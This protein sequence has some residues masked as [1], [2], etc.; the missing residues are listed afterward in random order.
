MKK[1]FIILLIILTK[2]LYSNIEYNQINNLFSGNRE[3]YIKKTIQFY[4]D[5]FENWNYFFSKPQQII[6]QNISGRNIDTVKVL[7]L[8]V[9]FHEDTSS[10]TTGNG[11]FTFSSNGEPEYNNDGT[12]NLNYDPPH[13]LVYFEH[14]MEALRNYYIDDTKGHLEIEYNIFPLGDTLS[15]ISLPH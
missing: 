3:K 6:R 15:K 10:L 9:D 8:R 14:Q 11:K 4:E 12:H 2:L 1:N 13:N 7:V 5:N